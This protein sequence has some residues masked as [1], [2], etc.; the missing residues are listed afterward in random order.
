MHTNDN[1][2]TFF[3]IIY[4]TLGAKVTTNIPYLLGKKEHYLVGGLIETTAIP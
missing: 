2:S 1:F 3:Y 4:L